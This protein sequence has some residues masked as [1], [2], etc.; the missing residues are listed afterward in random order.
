MDYALFLWVLFSNILGN[1]GTHI[2]KEAGTMLFLI[3]ILLLEDYSSRGCHLDPY[4]A[5]CAC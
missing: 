3:H 5:S 1:R 2:N 4:M